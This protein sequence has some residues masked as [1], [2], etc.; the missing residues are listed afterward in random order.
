[1][2]AT[3][4]QIRQT[5]DV[6]RRIV[7]GYRRGVCTADG[8]QIP[9]DKQGQCGK[10]SQFIFRNTKAYRDGYDRIDWGRKEK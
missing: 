4:A 3:R 7:E 8:G 1:M 5:E 6:K 9:K 2:V 10:G